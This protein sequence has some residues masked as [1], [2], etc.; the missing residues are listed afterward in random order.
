MFRV[1]WS[2]VALVETLDVV[3]G[4]SP[5]ELLGDIAIRTVAAAGAVAVVIP[6]RR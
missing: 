1:D 3:D 5:A 4:L 6:G 2:V